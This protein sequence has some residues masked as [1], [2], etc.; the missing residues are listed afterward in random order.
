MM[1]ERKVVGDKEPRGR[2]R[3]RQWR[4]RC[5]G[6]RGGNGGRI[7]SLAFSCSLGVWRTTRAIFNM[8]LGF[9]THFFPSH[10]H[11]LSSRETIYFTNSMETPCQGLRKVLSW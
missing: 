2:G 7:P 1:T 8:L 3:S 6:L 4:N 10:T 9:S 11:S 5:L